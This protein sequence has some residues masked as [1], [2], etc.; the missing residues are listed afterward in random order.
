MYS[1]PSILDLF[2]MLYE[3]N[4]DSTSQLFALGVSTILDVLPP[5]LPFPS[6]SIFHLIQVLLN[7]NLLSVR[8]CLN[9]L[10]EIAVEAKNLTHYP[11]MGVYTPAMCLLIVHFLH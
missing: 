9:I 10:S 5:L 6:G 8:F 4:I 7:N 11:L 2:V 3:K 1:I